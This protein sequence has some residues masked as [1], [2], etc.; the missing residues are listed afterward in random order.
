MHTYEQVSILINVLV[1]VE[2]LAVGVFRSVSE[3][4]IAGGKEA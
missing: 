4:G 1:G 3:S 2:E